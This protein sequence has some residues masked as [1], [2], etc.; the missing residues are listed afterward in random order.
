MDAVVRMLVAAGAIAGLAI[1]WVGVQALVRRNSP[2]MPSDCDVLDR[3]GCGGCCSGCALVPPDSRAACLESRH[4][5]G[6][7]P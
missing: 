3:E 5:Q 2:G 4:L 7:N 6:A 1:L